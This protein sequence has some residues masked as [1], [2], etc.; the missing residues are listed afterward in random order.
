MAWDKRTRAQALALLIVKQQLWVLRLERDFLL[1]PSL[2]SQRLPCA[3][4]TAGA[5]ALNRKASSFIPLAAAGV[6]NK[7]HWL[8]NSGSL[9]LGTDWR[10]IALSFLGNLAVPCT[11]LEL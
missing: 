6:G 7:S 5:Q 11:V 10:S 1:L 2:P 8:G 9:I 3:L 4:C